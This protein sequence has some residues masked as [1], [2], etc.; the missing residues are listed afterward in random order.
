M[1][2]NYLLWS[3]CLGLLSG[4]SLAQHANV[5][6]NAKVKVEPNTLVYFG[7]DFNIKEGATAAAVVENA[8]NVR[9]QGVFNNTGDASGANFVSTWTDAGNYG[10]VIINQSNN[11]VGRLAMEKG[12]I[13]PADFDWG[14]FSVPFHYTDAN[15]AML[16]LFGGTFT[17]GTT[18][19]RYKASMMRWNNNDQPRFD[20]LKAHYTIS[21][22]DY[23]ILNL[24]S[25]SANIQGPMSSS[26]LTYKGKPANEAHSAVGFT[27]S[28]YDLG[29]EWTD[30]RSLKNIYNEKYH[31]YIDD[32]VRNISANGPWGKYHYQFANPYTSNLN[33]A[34]IGADATADYD[35][36]VYIS[37]LIG[38][39][40]VDKVDWAINQGTLVNG[41]NLVATYE[42]TT[43]VWAGKAEALVIKPFEPFIIITDNNGSGS[44]NFSDKIKTFNFNPAVDGNGNPTGRNAGGMDSTNG[45]DGNPAI[46]FYQLGLNLYDTNGIP[47]GNRLYVVVTSVVENGV[48]NSLEAEYAGFGEGT[49]FYLGQENANGA[50]VPASVRKMHINTVHTSFEN[51]PIPMFLN[52]A[53]GD[54]SGYYLKADLFYKNIFNQLMDA[55]ANYT[56]GNSFY[57]FDDKEDI[58][59]PITSSFNYY[60]E[61]EDI[62]GAKTRYE[63]YW[64]ANPDGRDEMGTIDELAS[65]TV[66]YK[67]RN[68]HK[69]KF[70]DKWSTADVSV[71]DITGRNIMTFT[72]VNTKN[73][74]E[75]NLP[76][77]G[78]YVVRIKA[79]NGEV[80]TQ[81]VIK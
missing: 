48:E 12:R 1:N 56:D 53:E 23:I 77:A 34:F 22:T 47:T 10:Q 73:D 16:N 71:Y 13:N 69:V 64:N 58:F 51:K 3:M 14:Q 57:F 24:N 35:D 75:M 76:K 54:N 46:D 21:P 8:G 9:I 32:L 62:Y 30:W 67:D 74:F 78:A 4:M 26:K 61:P 50:P 15:D 19:N 25:A 59:I 65:S 42:Q 81:K 27:G 52:R 80:Y 2:N 72:N 49:G 70:D 36:G 38:V 37:G 31:T 29:T 17:N 6:G 79:N 55:D 45:V 18:S 20:H 40:Q 44:F 39:A 66:I 60:V 28:M 5:T 33:L 7:E 43:H 68:L 11:A 41:S 63:I